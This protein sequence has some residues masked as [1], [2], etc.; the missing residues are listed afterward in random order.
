MTKFSRFIYGVLYMLFPSLR[1]ERKAVI[2]Y[3]RLE[4]LNRNEKCYCGSDLKYK[5]CHSA[6]NED[7]NEIAVKLYFKGKA[8]GIKILP[9]AEYNELKGVKKSEIEVK[10]TF[11]NIEVGLGSSMD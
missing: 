3:D 2:K 8:V 10:N 5:R 1:K 7:A 11:S 6:L 9:K 4:E